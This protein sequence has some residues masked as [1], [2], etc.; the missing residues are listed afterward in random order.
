MTF[1][2]KRAF[3]FG[4][5]SWLL[6]CAMGD[7]AMAQDAAAPPSSTQLPEITV[8]APSPIVRRKPVVPSRTPARVARTAPGHNRERAPEPQAGAGRR[9]A[10]AGRAARRHRSICDRH[11]G[12]ERGNPP[13]RHRPARRSPVLEARHHRL[14]LRAGRLEP[15]DHPRP[16]RQ[17]RRHR[18]ERH[19]RRRRFRSRRRPFR[20]DRSTGDQ[21]GRSRSAARRRCATDRH[22]SAA[23]S[24]P[25]T[26]AFRM[27][28]P[29]ARRRRSRPTG[30]RRRRRWRTRN[31]RHA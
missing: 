1:K 11:R 5:A 4:G 22:R 20:A 13:P 21:P 10:P 2:K 31:H 9:R 19:R 25:P 29:P 18:R 28:C 24:A 26:I 6:L 12:A 16:R 8:T 3:H 23:S 15:A 30:C 27:P 17:P 7:G 14:Q